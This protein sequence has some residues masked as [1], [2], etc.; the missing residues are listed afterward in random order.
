M[1]REAM[2][3]AREDGNLC[4][5]LASKNL[6]CGVDLV[7][8]HHCVGVAD[9]DEHRPADSLDLV[10]NRKEGRVV[11]YRG[12]E[13]GVVVVRDEQDRVPPTPAETDGANL[14]ALGLDG[15]DELDKERLRDG[16]RWRRFASGIPPIYTEK[17]IAHPLGALQPRDRATR[18][19][20]RHR[21]P[22]EQEMAQ[23]PIAGVQWP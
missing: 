21:R 20:W 14:A 5:L 7:N 22:S 15:L 2:D 4:V 23:G 8:W 6:L 11:C 3:G 13:L 10:R 16:C 17:A 18:R 19:P 9:L 1:Y 12:I